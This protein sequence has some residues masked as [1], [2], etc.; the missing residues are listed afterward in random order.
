[1]CGRFVRAISIEDMCRAFGI[2]PPELVDLQP[3]YNIAPGQMV[4]AVRSVNGGQRE[5]VELRWGLIP[6]WSKDEKIGYK[7]INARSETV[8]E[9]PSFRHAIRNRRCIVPASGFYEWRR[10]GGSKIPHFIR[11][12]DEGIMSIAGLYDRWTAPD[13]HT[14]ES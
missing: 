9:K 13:G 4:A 1:M 14:I 11:R 5:L 3:R 10:Q 12:A 7:M 6:S 8:H 2:K